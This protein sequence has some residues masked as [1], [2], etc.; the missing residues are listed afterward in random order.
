MFHSTTCLQVLG[1]P[2]RATAEARVVK[3]SK[4]VLIVISHRQFEDHHIE[5]QP[6]ECELQGDDLNGQA[7]QIGPCGQPYHQLGTVKTSFKW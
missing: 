4:G 5:E 1:A 3:A 2:S 7:L 6:L